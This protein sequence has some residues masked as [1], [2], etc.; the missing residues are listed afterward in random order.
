MKDAL[1]LIGSGLAVL[2]GLTMIGYAVVCRLGRTP[3]RR[4]WAAGSEETARN[5]MLMLP[6]GGAMLAAV[7]FVGL[8]RRS[9]A[10]APLVLLFALL[11][12]GPVIWAGLRLPLPLAFYP[13]WARGQRARLRSR[14]KAARR[15][16]SSR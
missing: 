1:L 2:T 13:L 8:S 11:G 9:D 15:G 6:G 5:T 12:T 3:Q 10:F 7:G 16:A 4:E 14:Q